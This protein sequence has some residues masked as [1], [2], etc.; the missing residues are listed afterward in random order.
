MDIGS[1]TGER[2]TRLNVY[3]ELGYLMRHL[4]SQRLQVLCEEGVDIS[5]NIHDL[6]WA[7]FPTDKLAL[8]YR[9]ILDWLAHATTFVPKP[10]IVQ[11]ARQHLKRLDLLV[12]RK[13]LAVDEA[14]VAKQRLQNDINRLKI[15]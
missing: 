9:E 13:W 7:S 6:V 15:S 1:T 4:D 12:A 14:E 3:H 10:T 5:S 11:A 8:C 2:F